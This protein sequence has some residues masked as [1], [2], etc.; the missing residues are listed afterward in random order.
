MPASWKPDGYPSLSPYLVCHDAEGTIAFLETAFGAVVLR[1][2]D[3]DDGSLMHAEIRL[4]DSVLM[5]GGLPEASEN[6]AH[7][8]LYVPNAQA[9]FDRAVAAGG[10]VVQEPIRK[11]PNDDIRGG[12]KGPS[13]TTWWVA[14]QATSPA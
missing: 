8:H 3:R 6:E 5:I 12:I 7:I 11:R 9:T 1:R 2:L 14:T 10:T 4:D 13:G